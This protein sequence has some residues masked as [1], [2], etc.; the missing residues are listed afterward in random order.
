MNKES[1]ISLNDEIL[2]FYV[3]V[4]EEENNNDIKENHNNV[5][6]KIDEEISLNDST[7]HNSPNDHSNH[8][9]FLLKLYRIT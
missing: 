7:A 9:E 4:F 8:T 3:S 6:T 5:K 1:K 2:G